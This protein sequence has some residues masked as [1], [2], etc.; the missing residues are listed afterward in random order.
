MG[1][2]KTSVIRDE[3]ESIWSSNTLTGVSFDFPATGFTSSAFF[4]SSIIST[5]NP[6]SF[7]DPKL[8][9]PSDSSFSAGIDGGLLDFEVLR[10]SA[11]LDEEAKDVDFGESRARLLDSM[12]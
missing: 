8:I 12:L 11:E 6:P 10:E 5:L 2:E 9:L 7:A 3:V 4:F 1:D